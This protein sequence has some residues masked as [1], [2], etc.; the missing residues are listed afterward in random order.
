[1]SKISDSGNGRK[2]SGPID[3]LSLGD[4][5]RSEVLVGE[6]SFSSARFDRSN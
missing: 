4:L 5:C 6:T 3:F 2:C 1:M